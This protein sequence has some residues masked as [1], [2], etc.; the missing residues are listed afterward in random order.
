MKQV[1]VATDSDIHYVI[2]STWRESFGSS[3]LEVVFQG[4]GL[5]LVV[6][7]LHEGETWPFGVLCAIP[8]TRRPRTPQSLP[9]SN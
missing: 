3:Q 7:V 6:D 9:E 8:F 2:S 5:G 1:D 4:A